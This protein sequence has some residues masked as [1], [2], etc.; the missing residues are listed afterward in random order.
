M[1]KNKQV[2]FVKKINVTELAG[3]KVMV[4][5]EQGKYFLIRG[6]GNDIWEM[7]QTPTTPEAI[8][9]KLLQEYEVSPEEC[10]SSVMEFLTK[11]ENL[12]FIEQ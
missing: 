10:E 5:F 2:R 4:D 6:V 3:E 12:K 9:Q 7:L 8:I 11:L 1:D